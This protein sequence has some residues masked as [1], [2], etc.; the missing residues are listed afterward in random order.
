MVAKVGSRKWFMGLDQSE[1][2]LLIDHFEEQLE[3]ASEALIINQQKNGTDI[4]LRESKKENKEFFDTLRNADFENKTVKKKICRLFKSESGNN[5][6][7][8]EKYLAFCQKLQEVELTDHQWSIFCHAITS[9]TAKAKDIIQRDSVRKAKLRDKQE[10]RDKHLRLK[11]SQANAKKN[12]NVYEGFVAPPKQITS[13]A[14]IKL[15]SITTGFPDVDSRLNHL[16]SALAVAQNIHLN[17]EDTRFIEQVELS[18]LPL[19]LKGAKGVQ[20]SS[21]EIKSMTVRN[22]LEQLDLIVTR[23]EQIIA[24]TE[25]RVLENVQSQT[26]F[27][28]QALT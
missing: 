13:K 12:V 28:K 2:N 16:Q 21:V 27:L 10:A 20:H 19:I 5:Y 6:M 9:H 1:F 17:V 22:L 11:A 18:H 7:A 14:N 26:D 25:Q 3:I 8:F 24:D 23:L 4:F 15:Q